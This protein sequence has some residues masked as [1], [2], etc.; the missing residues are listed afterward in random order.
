MI[1]ALFVETGRR[2]VQK[3]ALDARPNGPTVWPMSQEQIISAPFPLTAEKVR[4]VA[5][6]MGVSYG[7]ALGFLSGV[8]FWME[9]GAPFEL[10]VQR[11]AQTMLDGCALALA[12][13][14]D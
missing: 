2:W 11:H 1:A 6:Q 13:L 8:A 3:L 10:A 5:K 4:L 12:K 9:K 7:D 14:G